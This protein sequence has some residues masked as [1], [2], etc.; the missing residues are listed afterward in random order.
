MGQDG[1][2]K[3]AS[4]ARLW[5]SAT[6]LA[7][8]WNAPALALTQAE[9]DAALA[10]LDTPEA[11]SCPEFHGSKLELPYEIKD[12]NGDAV[13]EIIVVQQASGAASCFGHAGSLISLLISDGKGGW[14]D[15]FGFPGASLQFHPRTDSAWPDIE[16]I[17]P[18]FCFPIWRYHEG[19]YGIWR[20][21]EE[22]KPVYAEGLRDGAVPSGVRLGTAQPVAARV[23]SM[24]SVEMIDIGSLDGIPYEHNGSIVIV[25]PAKGV[26]VYDRPK[27]SIAGT[28]KR[29][30]VL[31]RGAPWDMQ[32]IENVMING[33]AHTF[34]K[35]CNPTNYPVRG[36][37]HTTY[38]MSQFTLEG[39]A[40]IRS[41]T[42][43]EI[44]GHSVSNGNS[45]LVFNIAWD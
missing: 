14:Q 44:T 9:I 19:G 16:I 21:C 35:G 27:K 37:Y 31:F 17:G 22:G 40:P 6:L 25:D 36:L 4:A 13:D 28:I 20:T 42:G 33:T 18:G 3:T 11:R 26:I 10:T 5:I 8:A 41:K 1:S 43:C 2:G 15:Q 24:S 39:A 7:A 34:K 45:K 32:N 29:G 23:G 38:G 12:I 30:T